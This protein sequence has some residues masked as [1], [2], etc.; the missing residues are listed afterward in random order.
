[1]YLAQLNLALIVGTSVGAVFPLAV[2]ECPYECPPLDHMHV[3]GAIPA[4][5]ILEFR[6][7]FPGSHMLP[8]ATCEPCRGNIYLAYNGGGGPT[9]MWYDSSTAHGGPFNNNP[10]YARPGVLW[11]N[12]EGTPESFRAYLA[13]CDNEAESVCSILLWLTCGCSL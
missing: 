11:T 12:C 13:A 7:Q 2:N 9:C 4:E 1:M 3:V 6:G 8:C 10:P 5:F